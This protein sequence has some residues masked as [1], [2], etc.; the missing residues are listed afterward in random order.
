[1]I[2]EIPFDVRR[3]LHLPQKMG[4]Y[5][6]NFDNVKLQD[7]DAKKQ[8]PQWSGQDV[9]P[10]QLNELKSHW[11]IK[12]INRNRVWPTGMDGLIKRI[13]FILR[14]MVKSALFDG[15]MTFAVLC[16]TVTLSIDHYGIDP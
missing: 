11:I 8:L 5:E 12:Q 6:V 14:I 1:M 3:D 4:I 2:D 16:N 10:D 13:R 7:I 9:L 15:S